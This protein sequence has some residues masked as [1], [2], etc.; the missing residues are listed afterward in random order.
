M[1]RSGIL[2]PAGDDK[3][4]FLHNTFKAFFAAQRYLAIGE[5]PTLV[6]RIV[7]AGTNEL[8]SGLD[9]VAVFCAA[10]P[11]G[12]S[13]ADDVIKSLLL[14]IDKRAAR[15]VYSRD[16]RILVVRCEIVSTDMPLETRRSIRAI[17]SRLFT[18][19]DMAEARHLASLGEAIIPQLR[20]QRGMSSEEAAATVRC[21]R[22]IGGA[23]ADRL[24]D[25]YQDFEAPVVEEELAQ[26]R[27]PL[28]LQSIVAQA[29][30]RVRWRAV[31]KSVKA[32]IDDV[33]PLLGRRIES[34]YL[35]GTQVRDLSPLAAL[36]SLRVLDISGIEISQ[37]Q[38]ARL[39]QALPH[40][41][42]Y[43]D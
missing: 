37:E 30:D 21:L 22:L 12:Q 1:E 5:A 33:R 42:I 19:R 4:E 10:S 7:H 32:R 9:E 2:R 23:K 43:S 28:T 8:A 18:P 13:F 15:R 24:I 34:L 40:L 36:I 17:V 6:R 20:R 3:V 35:S 41:K 11:N 29:Q 14:E 25:D 16:L 27:N 31:P 38:V 39:R 26:V